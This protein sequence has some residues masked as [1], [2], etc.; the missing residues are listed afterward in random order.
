MDPA[1]QS[2]SPVQFLA[3]DEFA[4]VLGA[5]TLRSGPR[6]ACLAE[7]IADAIAQGLLPAGTRLPPDRALAQHLQV[8]RGTVVAAYSELAERA[9]VVRRQGSGTTV[10][11]RGRTPVGRHLRNEGFTRQVSGPAVPIDLSMAAPVH[12]DVVGRLLVSTGDAVAAGAPVHG[13]SPLGL[14]ALR[15]GIAARLTAR[16]V[17]TTASQILITAGAQGA[18]HLIIAAY[19]RP[20]DRAIVETPTDPGALELLSRAGAVVE[21]VPRDHAG[22]RPAQFRRALETGDAALALLVPTCHN[23]TGTTMSERRRHELL[24]A[25]RDEDV[26]LVEDL[27][28]ADTVFSGQAPPDLV[29]L[30]PD[31]VIAVGSFSKVLWG[32]LRTGWIRADP[33]TILRLGRLRTAQD[34]GSGVL[35]QVACLAALPRLDEIIAGRRAMA[36]ERCAVLTEA[37]AEQLPDWEVTAPDGGYGL[38]V[39]LPRANAPE[40]VAAALRHGVAIAGGGVGAVDDRHLDHVRICFTLEPD[41]LVEAAS[42]LREAWDEAA[43]GDAA[44]CAAPAV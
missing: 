9:L 30:E 25:I 3:V 20:G 7:A 14:P 11:A 35:D 38:W 10:S 29:A 2:Q 17:P 34:M 18:L 26:L 36:A 42:R 16:G 15:E 5:W 31:R 40:V 27:T 22:P 32:G 4:G 21:G 8:S 33:A 44:A 19:L 41:L 28:M 23:P 43:A 13:Y 24:A 1:D 37:L 6:Y 39:K 12:D